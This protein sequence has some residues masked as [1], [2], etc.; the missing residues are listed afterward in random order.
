MQGDKQG[1]RQG[2]KMWGNRATAGVLL[3]VGNSHCLK[4][5]LLSSSSVVCRLV[6]ERVAG[7]R[8][9]CAASEQ[10]ASRWAR[11]WETG[12]K[13]PGVSQ[14]GGN[15]AKL[16]GC[17]V[18]FINGMVAVSCPVGRVV[19]ASVRSLTGHKA[20]TERVQ[21]IGSIVSRWRAAGR[22]GEERRGHEEKKRGRSV[23]SYHAPAPACRWYLTYLSRQRMKFQS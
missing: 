2:D 20:Q 21:G 18:R 4:Y 5:N 10:T 22:L 3:A 12:E 17:L 11:T 7:K 8:T 19:S 15:G 9:Q 16:V 1:D 14:A 23:E 13:G 6:P